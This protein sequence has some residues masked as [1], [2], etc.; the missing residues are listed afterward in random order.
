LNSDRKSLGSLCGEDRQWYISPLPGTKARVK[1]W[2]KRTVRA[3]ESGSRQD[4]FSR[5][6]GD[7]QKKLQIADASGTMR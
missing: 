2:I 6:I 3:D 1:F 4:N 7:P 5:E